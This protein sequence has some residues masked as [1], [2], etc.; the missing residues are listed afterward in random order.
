LNKT[1]KDKLSLSLVDAGDYD[2]DGK[3]EVIF[4]VSGYNEDGYAMFYDAFR[5]NVFSTWSYH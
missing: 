2:G 5:K 3:A 4:F 1:D